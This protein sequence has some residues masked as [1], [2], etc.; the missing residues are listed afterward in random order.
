MEYKDFEAIFEEKFKNFLEQMDCTNSIVAEKG[1]EKLRVK[2]YRKPDSD[3]FPLKKVSFMVLEN[4]W[5]KNKDDKSKVDRCEFTVASFTPSSYI[6][7]PIFAF[8]ASIH[9]GLYDHLNVDLFMLS[10]DERYR[11]VFS[12]PVCELRKRY[13]S[14]EGLLP[15]VRKPMLAEYTSG[16]MMAGDFAEDQRDKTIPW[17]LDYVDL[18]KGFLDNFKNIPIL[19]DESVI[20]EGRK[21]GEMFASM[22]AKATPG[23]LNDVPNLADEETG[24]KLGDLLF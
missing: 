17:L 3:D 7:L 10:K 20:E 2:V 15:G 9:L 23:I 19:K 21:T 16:G 4:G 11:E 14:L 6:P 8:E 18:Y 13:D 12:K 22:F 1:E 24:K 5:V